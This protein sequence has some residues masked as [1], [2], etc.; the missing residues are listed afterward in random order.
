MKLGELFA[1]VQAAVPPG[2]AAVDVRSLAVDS[3][4]VTPG[5]LF[6][7]LPGANTDGAA[8][9]GQAVEKGAAAVLAQQPLQLPVPLVLA[10]NARKAFSLAAARFRWE[11]QETRSDIVYRYFVL[12]EN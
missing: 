10:S 11:N 3:R 1:G 2:A 9:A 5:T 6:A 12:G 8:F 4:R 7:A